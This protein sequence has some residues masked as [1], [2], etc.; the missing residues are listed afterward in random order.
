[1]NKLSTFWKRYRIVRDYCSGFAVEVW[2][3]WWPFW[4]ECDLANSHDSIEK[5]EEYAVRHSEFGNGKIIKEL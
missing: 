5:A 1:M 2:R 4:A 3:I